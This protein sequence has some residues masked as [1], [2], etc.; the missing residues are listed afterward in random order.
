MYANKNPLVT[1]ILYR[2]GALG[3]A[4]IG[5]WSAVLWAL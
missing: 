2:F 5:L 4:L 1:G 3:I